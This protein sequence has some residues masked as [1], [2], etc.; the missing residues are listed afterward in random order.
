M[1]WIKLHLVYDGREVYA[2]TENINIVNKDYRESKDVT[3]I[4]FAGDTEN[5]IRVTESVEEVMK[6]IRECDEI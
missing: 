3:C 6:R 4:S 2:N 1:A 5:Y